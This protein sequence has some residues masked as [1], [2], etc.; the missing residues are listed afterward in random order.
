[1]SIKTKEHFFYL[2]KLIF[3]G[4]FIPAEFII[5]FRN[6]DLGIGINTDW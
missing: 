1:M 2:F 5:Y 4:T 3:S 6:W